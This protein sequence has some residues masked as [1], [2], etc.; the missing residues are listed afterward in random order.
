MEMR[1][2]CDRN[3]EMRTECDRSIKMRTE[4]DRNMEKRTECDRSI[5]M[6]TEC[7]RNMEKRTE[8]ARVL[9]VCIH[10]TH[11]VPYKKYQDLSPDPGA[12]LQMGLFPFFLRGRDWRR[13]FGTPKDPPPPHHFFN[14]LTP[15]P[16]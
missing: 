3:M 9:E 5:K 11:Q 16:S 6:R 2:E 15:S 8:C 13:C 7:D 10:A 1:T 4:C 12:E 14:F